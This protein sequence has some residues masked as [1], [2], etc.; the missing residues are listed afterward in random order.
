MIPAT[1]SVGGLVDH[2]IKTPEGIR[3]ILVIDDEAVPR[4]LLAVVLGDAGYDVTALGK[5]DDIDLAMR[6]KTFELVITDLRMPVMDGMQVMR[7]VHEHYPSVLVMMVTAVTE[8]ETAV[9]AMKTGAVD[10]LTKP[11]NADAVLMSVQ[12]ADQVYRLQ[13]ENQSYREGLEALVEQ[14]TAQI[15]RFADA[16]S[17]KNQMILKANR[18]LHDANEKLQQFLNHAMVMDKVSTIGLLSSMLIHGIANP[19]GV[20]SGI[21]E[22]MQKRFAGDAVTAKELTMMQNYLKQV[23]DLVNQIRSYAKTEVVKFEAVDVGDAIR[24]AVTMFQLL[25]RRKDIRLE[26]ELPDHALWISGNPSQLEQVLANLIQN[27]IHAIEK[28]GV[29]RITAGADGNEVR[30]DITDNGSGIPD[31]HQKRL[32]KMFFTTKEDGRGTG[33][34]LFICN[35]IVAKHKGQIDLQSEVGKGTTVTLRFPQQAVA[36]N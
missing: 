2:E 8:T 36:D 23:L 28:D 31:E 27:A 24:N 7:F 10:Y 14:R 6:G 5:P 19:L 12:R 30:V 13:K 22:V 15:Y 26:T 34:G 3:R 35:E 9:E 32:F 4:Q 25:L 1:D 16:L 17:L 11:L 33:L 20:V 18:E 29:I 21:A